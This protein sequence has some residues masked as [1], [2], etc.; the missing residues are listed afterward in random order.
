MP[1]A[2]A[3]SL[4]Q[5][6]RETEQTRVGLTDTVEQLRTSVAE[7]ASDIRQ[8]IRPEAIKAEVSDYIK[9][10]GEQLLN[11]VTA[12]ARRNP[13]QA[14]AVGASVAYPLLR[15]ARAIPVPILMVGAGLFF[16]GSKTGQAA[17][18]RASDVASDL[19]DEAMRRARDLGNQVGDAVSAAKT[20][21]SDRLDRVSSAVSGGTDQVSQAAGS[22]SATIA[23]NAQRVQEKATSFGASISDRVTDVRDSGIRMAGSAAETL[24]DIASGAASAGQKTIGSVADAG[25]EAARAARQKASDL[26]ERAGKTIF[27]TI[28]QNPLLVAGVGLL[29]GGLIAS[30]LPRSD[31]EDEMIGDASSAVK[32]RAQS[33]ASQGFDAARK[34]VGEV[35]DE[36]VRQAE[37]EGLSTD[38]LSKSAQD[39]GQRVRRVAESAVTTAFEPAQDNQHSRQDNQHSRSQGETH[40]D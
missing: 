11:D 13:M 37:A 33:A 16:A 15:L 27:E 10:R 40:H 23:S 4:E 5:I 25:L 2:E 18:Q 39:I 14:V 20:Y 29:I 12:A 35:Y 17:T 22:A 6:K 7:T 26:T 1:F 9:S 36:A 30:A 31:I 28:E 19:S 24:Q 3:R 34:A 8:R 21:A 32:R 38:G